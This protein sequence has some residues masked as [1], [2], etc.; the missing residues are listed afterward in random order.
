MKVLTAL[1]SGLGPGWNLILTDL[2]RDYMMVN[3]HACRPRCVPYAMSGQ[4]EAEKTTLG[5]SYV[6][7]M[8]TF[9]L[10]KAGSGAWR[11]RV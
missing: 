4:G 10:L 2:V 6:S 3:R 8:L 11:E 9:C 1:I 7:F 5:N